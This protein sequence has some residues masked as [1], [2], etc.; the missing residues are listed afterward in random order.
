[1]HARTRM[2]LNSLALVVI[3]GAGNWL[4]AMTPASRAASSTSL[5][6]QYCCNGPTCNCC[7]ASV[8]RCDTGG[9]GCL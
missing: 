2:V 4:K 9:C 6:S 7:G 5:L 8:A 3:G 1:M